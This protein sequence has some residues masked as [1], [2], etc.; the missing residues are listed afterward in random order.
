MAYCVKCGVKLEDS[1]KK[2]PLCQTVVYHPDIQEVTDAV[3]PFPEEYEIKQKKMGSK[4]KLIIATIIVFLPTFLTLIC[5]YSINSRIV[6][7]DIVISSVCLLYCFIFVPLIFRR[8]NIFFY[9]FTDF[10]ALLL[11]QWYIALTTGGSWFTGFSLP[12]TCSVMLIVT[13]VVAV[14]QFTKSSYLL[15]S[16]IAFFLTGLDCVLTEFLISR[17]F[18]NRVRFIWSYYPLVTFIAVGIILLLC[19]RN[20]HFKEKIVKKFFI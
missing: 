14:R 3:S 2:C 19:D 1:E 15:I 8:K 10:A 20:T 6:W 18:M 11:F 9:L 13:V 16:A 12:F 17:T 4:L 5:D 7:S